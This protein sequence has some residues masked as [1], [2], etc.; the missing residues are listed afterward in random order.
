MEVRMDGRGEREVR[1]DGREREREREVVA[2]RCSR[3]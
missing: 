1:R 3:P 2:V